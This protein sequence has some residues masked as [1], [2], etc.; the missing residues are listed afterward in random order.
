MRMKG[1]EPSLLTKP[2][3][4]SGAS[5]N[6]AISAHNIDYYSTDNSQNQI[7]YLQNNDWRAIYAYSI[8]FPVFVDLPLVEQL[9][10][11]IYF[12]RRRYE[13]IAAIVHADL[14]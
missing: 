1:L 13:I 8:A 2:E 12:N 3:P 7:L 10:F 11:H 5:T 4:K 14:S 6:S 9:R